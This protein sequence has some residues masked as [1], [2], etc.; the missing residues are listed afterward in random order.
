MLRTPLLLVVALFVCSVYAYVCTDHYDCQNGGVCSTGGSVAVCICQPNW[1]GANCAIPAG[2]ISNCGPSNSI[3]TV[4]GTCQCIDGWT[5]SNCDICPYGTGCIAPQ[6]INPTCTICTVSPP[7]I[8]TTVT[9]APKL[10]QY[11]DNTCSASGSGGTCT[12]NINPFALS[13]Q[14]SSGQYC[15]TY[16]PCSLKGTLSFNGTHCQCRSAMF[17]PTCSFVQPDPN[18]CSSALS[19]FRGS[20]M[21]PP[22][23]YSDVVTEV[24]SFLDFSY[25]T[26]RGPWPLSYAYEYST[27]Y[28]VDPL[29][30]SC[31]N[32]GYGA[33]CLGSS[34]NP[35][36]N[37]GTNDPT[38][39]TC[40]PAYKGYLCNQTSTCVVSNTLNTTNDACVCDRMHYGTNC[41]STRII[42]PQA[43][44]YAALTASWDGIY[45]ICVH[46]VVGPVCKWNGGLSD[47]CSYTIGSIT[48]SRGYVAFP[49]YDGYSPVDL[50][51]ASDSVFYVTGYYNTYGY[52]PS[53]LYCPDREDGPHYGP[54]CGAPQTEQ[55]RNGGISIVGGCNCTSGWTGF[56]CTVVSGCIE[57]NTLVYQNGLC[58]CKAG[59]SGGSCEINSCGVYNFPCNGH[60]TCTG[61]VCTCNGDGYTG[62]ICNDTACGLISSP[63]SG[64]GTCNAGACVCTDPILVTGNI[65]QTDRCGSVTTPC[66]GVGQC[67]LQ[68]CNCTHPLIT[69]GTFCQT[70]TGCNVDHTI[71]Y[72]NG[73]CVCQT[74]WVDSS[75]ASRGCNVDG[76]SLGVGTSGP[77]ICKTGYTGYY[78][79]E[80]MCGN[81]TNPCSGTGAC[82]VFDVGG[83]DPCK[84]SS[85]GV[86]WP[87]NRDGHQVCSTTPAPPCQFDSINCQFTGFDR[88]DVCYITPIPSSS[89]FC[90]VTPVVCQPLSAC[91]C[92]DGYSGTFCKDRIYCD[93]LGTLNITSTCNCKPHFSGTSCSITECGTSNG[94]CNGHGSCQSDGTCT[95]TDY[96]SG[97]RCTI[98]PCATTEG[99]SIC[100]NNGD[101]VNGLCQCDTYAYGDHCNSTLGCSITG[102]SYYNY[103]ASQCVCKQGQM[104][105]YC[106]DYDGFMSRGGCDFGGQRRCGAGSVWNGGYTCSVT[107]Q[108]NQANMISA[109]VQNCSPFGPPYCNPAP[110][111]QCQAG[112]DQ[113][114]TGRCCEIGASFT[115]AFCSGAHGVY[116]CGGYCSAGASDQCGAVG[117]AGC[118]YGTCV[119]SGGLAAGTCSCNRGISGPFCDQLACFDEGTN[120]QLYDSFPVLKTATSCSCKDGW[121]GVL[122]GCSPPFKPWGTLLDS[123]V[124]ATSCGSNT[125]CATDFIDSSTSACACPSGYG[126]TYCCMSSCNGHGVCSLNQTTLIPYC[127]CDSG[128]RGVA[129]EISSSCPND[130]SG[131][132]GGACVYTD[133]TYDIAE[134]LSY[135]G[136]YSSLLN[137]I[138]SALFGSGY[139][140]PSSVGDGVMTT[141]M[142]FVQSP[143][144]QM[145]RYTYSLYGQASVRSWLSV[146]LSRLAPQLTPNDA[147]ISSLAVSI[148]DIR[149]YLQYTAVANVLRYA[150]LLDS[151]LAPL[152]PIVT[153][154]PFLHCVCNPS[155][156]GLDCSGSCTTSGLNSHP[157]TGLDYGDFH[158]ICPS[159]QSCLCSSRYNKDASCSGYIGDGCY[160]SVSTTTPCHGRGTCNVYIQGVSNCS[161][162]TGSA[163]QYCDKYLCSI[164]DP[165]P[166]V[167]KT[168]CSNYGQCL[169]TGICACYV[170]ANLAT[171][172]SLT[173]PPR[174]PVGQNCQYDAITQCGNAVLL[175]GIV[176]QWLEC[177]GRGV[178]TNDTS[179]ASPYCVCQSGYS[180][181][182]CTTSPC[183][184]DCNLH[185]SCQLG[186]GTC[187]CNSKWTTPVSG[188]ATGN[189][190]CE[191]SVSVCGHGI[192]DASGT[193]C[194]CD[195]NYRVDSAGLCTIVQCPLVKQT[196]LG[197]S[198]CT[199]SCTTTTADLSHSKGCCYD[200]C[201][202]AQGI[203]QCSLN[204][205]GNTTCAC[206][207][208]AAFT[209]VNGICYSKCHGQ[210]SFD[211]SGPMGYNCQCSQ[212]Y[213][214]QNPW[215]TSTDF[216]YPDSIYNCLRYRCLNGGTVTSPTAVKCNCPVNW[217]GTLCDKSTTIPTPSLSSSSSTGVSSSSTSIITSSS[218]GILLSSSTGVASSTSVVI[219]SSSSSS[220]SHSSSSTGESSSTGS[221]NSTGSSSSSST[222]STGA[223]A[224]IAVSAGI[225]AVLVGGVAVYG[226]PT[227]AATA[228]VVAGRVRSRRA[229][230]DRL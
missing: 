188:C 181:A 191:C 111:Y 43:S 154:R 165:D 223:I 36:L 104:P 201:K 109:A 200:A 25:T 48:Y 227:L 115:V 187:S 37:G 16:Y 135:H 207:S 28:H 123:T 29:S 177:N 114:S 35:C 148:S 5:G 225:V 132:I 175:G 21:F 168:Q 194:I 220:G 88:P 95:C 64:R 155:R 134:R 100:N 69:T 41:E 97:S 141:I 26:N 87:S 180:G 58:H 178:C 197:E 66:S 76:S 142:R 213:F 53:Y 98:A 228:V 96:Y 17:G 32:G 13:P 127:K 209:Q 136:D 44:C 224:G 38:G 74:N 182:K 172:S 162:N 116:E 117:D 77:C 151:S 129:C 184:P 85:S 143:M 137:N 81:S 113:S 219:A 163:G 222:L 166:I 186:T 91:V 147:Y 145:I 45:C 89:S 189:R 195:A 73:S 159:S 215:V 90:F 211:V 63:C 205:A 176:Y 183:S 11:H 156:S 94:V 2:P 138:T 218:T 226:L 27:W 119:T 61:G 99:G 217:T 210:P 33:Y 170:S 71:A 190:T 102:T 208:S 161:C 82:Q 47:G 160:D 198:I 214:I 202:T 57:A 199:S 18:W 149:L 55:C 8:S 146:A 216:W 59:Y 212:S 3:L 54:F 46:N 72:T 192:P 34:F 173:N 179:H 164:N 121:T 80:Y 42:T 20:C 152:Y 65:C 103:T 52:E 14:Q 107:V 40:P 131:V 230:F 133:Y 193:S 167:Q 84:I 22:T 75:C 62:P 130:C 6:D 50:V 169:G 30:C 229:E 15:Q 60:G 9:I 83:T 120:V 86:C 112:Y 171:S 110:S 23:S 203:S 49:R 1:K 153:S 206:I 67:T 150:S 70:L 118:V 108:G 158:G 174:L 124:T 105:P 122:C 144:F 19:D 221:S 92:N 12:C 185:Q 204:T 140:N 31:S 24:C 93:P 139:T 126:G 79:D 51:C 78:C 101:C 39:C 7:M 10:M 128:F 106:C 125:P 157:C 4:N 196:D 56:M 68:G